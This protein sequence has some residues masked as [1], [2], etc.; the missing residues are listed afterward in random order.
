MAD[1]GL[2]PIGMMTDLD[3]NPGKTGWSIPLNAS[4]MC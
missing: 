4:Q 2:T 3:Q 1:L